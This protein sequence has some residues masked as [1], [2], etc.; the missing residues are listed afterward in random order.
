ME[1]GRCSRSGTER[2]WTRVPAA[3]FRRLL[4]SNYSLD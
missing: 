3:S 4:S 2:P 1:T